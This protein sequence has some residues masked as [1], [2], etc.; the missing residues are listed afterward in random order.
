VGLEL[1][2]VAAVVIGGGSLAGGAG[3]VQA[4]RTAWARPRAGLAR[5][6]ARR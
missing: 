3:S 2:V 6:R 1:E 4:R 5:T